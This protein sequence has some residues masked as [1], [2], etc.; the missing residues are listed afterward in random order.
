MTLQDQRTV[1]STVDPDLTTGSGGTAT[2]QSM[3]ETRRVTSTPSGSELARRLIVLIFGLIQLVIGLRIVLLLL[4]ARTGNAIVSSILNISQV[5]VAPFEG[6]L[7]TNALH[8]GGSML[9]VAAVVALVGWTVL[10]AIILWALA[11]F[12]RDPTMA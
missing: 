6:I 10:E 3:I 8:A 5:F 2:S 4:D 7:R 1:V 12:Q 11:I 9:D